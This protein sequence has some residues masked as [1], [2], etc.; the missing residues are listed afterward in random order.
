MT[1]VIDQSLGGGNLLDAH[2]FVIMYSIV[3]MDDDSVVAAC[4]ALIIAVTIKKRRKKRSIWVKKWLL[5]R[6]RKGAYN[7]I[8]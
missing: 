3:N 6:D 8:I 5:E 1:F 2:F 4:A 7:N